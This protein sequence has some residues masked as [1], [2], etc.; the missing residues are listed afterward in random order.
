M[1]WEGT[2]ESGGDRVITMQLY[3]SSFSYGFQYIIIIQ[4]MSPRGAT[5]LHVSI[6]IAIEGKKQALLLFY[7]IIYF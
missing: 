6:I 4:L 3:Q 1:K 7:F 5:S 2:R